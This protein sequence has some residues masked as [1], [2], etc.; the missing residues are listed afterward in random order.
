MLSP[1]VSGCVWI[2]AVTIL[3]VTRVIQLLKKPW[4][5]LFASKLWFYSHDSSDVTVFHMGDYYCS[6]VH[7]YL[8]FCCFNNGWQTCTAGLCCG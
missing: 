1:S 5:K 6:T 4:C 3:Q 2:M 7:S 8:F